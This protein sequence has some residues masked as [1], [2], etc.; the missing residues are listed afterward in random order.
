MCC[1]NRSHRLH[2]QRGDHGQRGGQQK[3]LQAEPIVVCHL[4]WVIA[5]RVLVCGLF[6]VVSV[7]LGEWWCVVVRLVVVRCVI[8]W[9]LGCGVP[10][11]CLVMLG[12]A[13][14]RLSQGV[15]GL[16]SS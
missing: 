9:V 5:S 8:G 14:V 12:W 6:V 7:L 4:G 2:E 16:G 11:V 1:W 3:R 15:Q 13:L 10:V